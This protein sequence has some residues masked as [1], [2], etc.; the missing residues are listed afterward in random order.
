M[1]SQRVPLTRVEHDQERRQYEADRRLK[2]YDAQ[3]TNGG[4]PGQ[5]KQ[6]EHGNE[7][8]RHQRSMLQN[9]VTRRATRFR[10]E[11]E[12]DRLQRNRNASRQG[13]LAP[14]NPRHA[15]NRGRTR[16]DQCDEDQPGQR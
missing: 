13:Q 6:C 12:H 3:P 5:E 9:R 15:R 4:D 11:S 10:G 14:H 8:C 7:C 2:T 16:H 1:S